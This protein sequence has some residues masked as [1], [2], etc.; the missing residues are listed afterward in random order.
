MLYSSLDFGSIMNDK[1][2]GRREIKLLLISFLFT[3]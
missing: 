1:G 3:I 2:L